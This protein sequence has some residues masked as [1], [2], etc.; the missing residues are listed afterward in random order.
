MFELSK[1][2]SAKFNFTRI[3]AAIDATLFRRSPTCIHSN[4]G[5]RRF[6]KQPDIFKN[7]YEMVA[8]EMA[9]V[10]LQEQFC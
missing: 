9:D 5:N 7:F 6:S 4:W 2:D 1:N 10:K 8:N 3:P